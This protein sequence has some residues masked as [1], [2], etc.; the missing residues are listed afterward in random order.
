MIKAFWKALC[1]KDTDV[2]GSISIRRMI[3]VMIKSYVPAKIFLDLPWDFPQPDQ[4][5]KL[6]LV[7][8]DQ[9]WV[10][11]SSAIRLTLRKFE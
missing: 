8:V 4:N 10:H 2:K 3:M 7:P 5:I 6:A 1:K 9:G 11:V